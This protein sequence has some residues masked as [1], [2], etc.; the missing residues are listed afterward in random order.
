MAEDYYKTLG[1]SRGASAEEIQKA[2]R[3]LARKYHPDL[4][5]D[6][7]TAKEKFQE[8][9][10]AFDVLN[11]PDKRKK[12][13]QFGHAF[14]QMG[15]GGPG[16]QPQYT[17][18]GGA[19][20]Q[21][22]PQGGAFNFEDLFGG[23]GSG[24]LGDIFRQFG[25]VG[26]DA[27]TAEP[28]MPTRGADIEHELTVPFNTA[29]NGGEAQIMVQRQTGKTETIRVKIPA[30]IE[31]GKKIRLRGQGDP[32]RKKSQAGD[33]LITIHVA[34]H[35]CFRRRG[36]NLYV[37]VPVALGEAAGGSKIDLPSP[38]GTITLS[39]PPGSSSGTKLR[40]AGHGVQAQG[41]P[42]GDLFAEVQIVLP[43][44]LT[45]EDRETL[46][47]LSSNYPENPRANLQW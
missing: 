11:D 36:N 24:G 16:G 3:D 35:P 30:G 2:H 13:D 33:I 5:P 43:K 45:K 34:E 20:P 38:T 1:V 7:K 23:G 6:D 37:T 31:D 15:Q 22:G 46:T 19:G 9:Q 21:G 29:I 32:G 25:G 28:Q 10:I 18:S 41:K 39:I 27:S 17:W 14:E 8:V 40:V 44:K 42:R 12:Y 26:A 47:T 4:N